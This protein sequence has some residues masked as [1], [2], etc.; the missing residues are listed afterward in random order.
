MGG[1]VAAWFEETTNPMKCRWEATAA[2]LA[3]S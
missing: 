2:R 3:G 1:Q